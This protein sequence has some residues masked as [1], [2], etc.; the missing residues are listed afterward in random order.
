[1]QAFFQQHAL[2]RG[3]GLSVDGA[4]SELDLGR[5]PRSNDGIASGDVWRALRTTLLKDFGLLGR[6]C[7]LLGL[8]KGGRGLVLGALLR[9][10][11]A[12]EGVECFLTLAHRRLALLELRILL[13][14]TRTLGVERLLQLLQLGVFLLLVHALS[15]E[16]LL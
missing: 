8:A 13:L 2:A 11:L 4:L 9:L 10:L 7:V 3:N 12:L 14:L 15:F 16:R 6:G 5:G 1:M